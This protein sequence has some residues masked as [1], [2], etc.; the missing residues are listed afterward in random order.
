MGLSTTAQ[1]SDGFHQSAYNLMNFDFLQ[2]LYSLIQ[3]NIFGKH[4][5]HIL[6]KN[7]AEG[8]IVLVPGFTCHP[9]TLRILAECL[10]AQLWENHNIIFAKSNTSWWLNHIE[11]TNSLGT[12][13][14]SNLQDIHKEHES[15]GNM[16]IIGHSLGW[17]V[18]IQAVLNWEKNKRK[19]KKSIWRV[20]PNDINIHMIA[21][22]L[23]VVPSARYPL[24]SF[25][26]VLTELRK[27]RLF[28]DHEI[29]V[30]LSEIWS[31]T[32]HITGKDSLV[33]Q[34]SQ[35]ITQYN[36]PKMLREKVSQIFHPHDNHCSGINGSKVE[37]LATRIA[38]QINW[39]LVIPTT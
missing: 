11:D 4:C 18:T 25:L 17:P 39:R 31:L 24:G 14:L 12:K 33:P 6:E 32:T 27:S 28:T 38:E 10:K 29:S 21:S 35:D 16:I 37:L 7:T 9:A 5:D 19:Q 20:L 34:T 15:N 3:D 23:W 26:P 1:H 8:T 22:P 36:I 13:L 2:W 30:F